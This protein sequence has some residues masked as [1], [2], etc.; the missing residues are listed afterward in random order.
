MK[1]GIQQGK[2]FAV[3]GDEA[4]DISNIEQMPIVI[5]L[6]D[7]KGN[8]EE[9]FTA[10]DKGTRGKDIA[11]KIFSTF[12]ELGLDINNCR[13]QGYDWAG[14]V[15]GK[16]SGAAVRMQRKFPK[17]SYVHCTSHAHNLCVASACNIQMV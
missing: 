15:A 14:N 2:F 8:I 9:G 16:C 3:L 6:V 4:A 12:R 5:R 1:K 13:G 7:L 10:C 17:A 11:H